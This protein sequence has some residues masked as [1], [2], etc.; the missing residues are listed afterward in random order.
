MS[1]RG[2]AQLGVIDQ[3]QGVTV[4]MAGASP[5]ERLRQRMGFI[6]RGQRDLAICRRNGLI[7]PVVAALVQQRRQDGQ[8]FLALKHTQR[9]WLRVMENRGGDNFRG[10]SGWQ[11]WHRRRHRLYP[12]AHRRCRCVAETHPFYPA[13]RGC[14]RWK[15]AGAGR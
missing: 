7:L 4:V 15:A 9:H 8:Q 1:S 3:P 5:A 6:Q 12:A 14:R 13:P 2:F 11:K 10:G